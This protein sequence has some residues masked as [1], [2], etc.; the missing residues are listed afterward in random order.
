MPVDVY[1][2]FRNEKTL[3]CSIL[4]ISMCNYF[5]DDQ[6]QAFNVTSRVV[7]LGVDAHN[8]PS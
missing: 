4:A 5:H 7:E 2:H 8:W 3:I 6:S 1:K